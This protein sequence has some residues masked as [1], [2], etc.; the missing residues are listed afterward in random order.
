MPQRRRI[1]PTVETVRNVC[2]CRYIWL[3]YKAL[4]SSW[5]DQLLVWQ[6]TP[7]SL[8]SRMGQI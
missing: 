3:V 6:V 4:T 8:V 5:I 2:R 7:R 1:Y